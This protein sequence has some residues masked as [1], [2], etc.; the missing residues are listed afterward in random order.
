MQE[1]REL[2]QMADWTQTRTARA[3]GINRAKISQAECGEID[4]SPT[5]DAAVRRVL[6]AAIRDRAVRIEGVLAGA[7]AEAVHT[8]A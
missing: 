4:L 2:R 1:L 8:G 3:S 5:E 6:L 7:N